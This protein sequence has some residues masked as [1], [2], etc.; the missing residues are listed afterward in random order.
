[1]PEMIK[2]KSRDIA[3][4][5]EKEFS[6]NINQKNCK[7]CFDDQVDQYYSLSDCLHEFCVTCHASMLKTQINDG[8]VLAIKC[9]EPK[10]EVVYSR[11][12]VKHVLDVIG[13]QDEDGYFLKYEKFIVRKQLESDPLIKWCPRPGC[14][15]HVKAKDNKAT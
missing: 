5:L 11:D 8:Q 4:R 12:Q 6:Q 2:Q 13:G 15:N 7:I 9:M 1:M 3:L 14:E 10:C